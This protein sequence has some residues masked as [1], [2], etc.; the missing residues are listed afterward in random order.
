MA[1]RFLP[2][3]GLAGLAL[4]STVRRILA[5]RRAIKGIGLLFVRWKVGRTY[6]RADRRQ[7]CVDRPSGRCARL[8]HRHRKCAEVQPDR[9]LSVENW[10]CVELA[11]GHKNRR[12]V[13]FIP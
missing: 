7:R 13:G 12:I 5:L 8:C 9:R 3:P 6:W 2:W 11:T 10:P 1:E 4:L